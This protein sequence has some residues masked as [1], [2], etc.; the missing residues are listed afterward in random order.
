[1]IYSYDINNV[2]FVAVLM[3]TIFTVI[4]RSQ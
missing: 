3:H 2:Q 4:M 1:M